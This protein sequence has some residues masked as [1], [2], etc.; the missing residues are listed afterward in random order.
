MSEK[1]EDV[2]V[3]LDVET[4][5]LNPDRENLLEVGAIAID[6]DTLA[7]RG[8][9]FHSVVHYKRGAGV[10]IDPFVEKMHTDNGLWADCADST[11]TRSEMF[12]A[13]VIWMHEQ[14]ALEGNVVLVGN[15]VH[16][17]RSYLTHP[18]QGSY[19]LTKQL[20]YRMVDVR[21]VTYAV[22]SWLPSVRPKDLEPAHRALPDAH[23]SLNLLRWLKGEM[24][25]GAER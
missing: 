14:G 17:D 3:V 19:D 9:M 21:S 10:E 4:T 20:H 2:F 24:R 6:F 22:E 11:C 23:Y 18:V 15:S 12:R 8:P 13:L 25:L 16:F 7:I 1:P 5:G